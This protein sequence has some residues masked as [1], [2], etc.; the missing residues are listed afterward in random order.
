MGGGISLITS[1]HYHGPAALRSHLVQIPGQRGISRMI[2]LVSSDSHTDDNRPFESHGKRLR[3]FYGKHNVIFRI[4]RYILRNQIII[5]HIRFTLF[6]LYYN[7]I[8]FRRRSR[9][10]SSAVNGASCRNPGHTCSMLQFV[11]GRYDTVWITVL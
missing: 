5:P 11:S 4:S 9:V 8:G 6:Q 7:D 2:P 3:I 1:R 10:C